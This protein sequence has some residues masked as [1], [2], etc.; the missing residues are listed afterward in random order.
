MLALRDVRRTLPG[1]PTLH[2]SATVTD[3]VLEDIY[4]IFELPPSVV[5]SRVDFSR[6]STLKYEVQKVANAAQKFSV[7]SSIISRV[8]DRHQQ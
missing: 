8:I 7:V 2:T 4:G 6:R 5:L 3:A 1:V